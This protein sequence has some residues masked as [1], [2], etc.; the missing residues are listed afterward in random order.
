MNIY[1][2]ELLYILILIYVIMYNVYS[3]KNM[4]IYLR[5][6]LHILIYIIMTNVYSR[7]NMN[8]SPG[9]TVYTYLCYYV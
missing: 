4:N 1:L 9:V 5:E 6:L 3:R 2:Q 7:Q 8:I